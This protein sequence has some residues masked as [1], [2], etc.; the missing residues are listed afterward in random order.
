MRQHLEW[1]ST[2]EGDFRSANGYYTDDVEALMG[3]VGDEGAFDFHPEVILEIDTATRS[4]FVASA[5]HPL[6]VEDGELRELSVDQSWE[7]KR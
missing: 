4:T 2:A 7:P 3:H 1:V 6:R 5:V